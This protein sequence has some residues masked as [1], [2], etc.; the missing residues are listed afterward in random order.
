MDIGF[1]ARGWDSNDVVSGKLCCVTTS[2]GTLA[3]SSVSLEVPWLLLR[4]R[5]SQAQLLMHEFVRRPMSAHDD[6]GS[7]QILRRRGSIA[8]A[9]CW[10]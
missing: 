3:R 10:L 1:F 7:C 6:D 8:D 2:T 4:S 9:C 5:T